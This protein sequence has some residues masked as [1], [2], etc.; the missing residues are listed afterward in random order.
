MYDI[1]SSFDEVTIIEPTWYAQALKK[2]RRI[3]DA[4]FSGDHGVEGLFYTL[5]RHVKGRSD[6]AITDLDE[7]SNSTEI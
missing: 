7:G 1:I 2:Y 4:T 6:L 3:F 5:S